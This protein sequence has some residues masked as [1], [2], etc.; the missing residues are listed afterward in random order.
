MSF[1]EKI[2]K[3]AA[4]QKRNIDEVIT[5]SLFDLSAS[6]VISTPVDKGTLANSWKASTS[7]PADGVALEGDTINWSSV[8]DTVAASV[9][10]VYYFVNNQPYAAV[11]EYEGHSEKAPAG[12]LRVN[13]ENYG[14]MLDTAIGNVTN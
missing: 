5:E 12:M 14:K 3:Y 6:V 4:L 2:R 8:E 10:G 11:I 9:G 13:L 7:A 1:S